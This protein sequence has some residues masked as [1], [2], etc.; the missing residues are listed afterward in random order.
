MSAKAIPSG[1]HTITP[2]FS[3][4]DAAALVAFLKRAF[5]AKEVDVMTS[6]D[7]S[8]MHAQL[9]VGN[10]MV[11]LGQVPPDYPE[12]KLLKAMLYMYIDDVDAAYKKAI[13]AGGKSVMEPTNQFYG[14]RSGAVDDP[15]GNQW[16]IATHIEDMSNEELMRRASQRGK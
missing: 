14:D 13:Q 15:A 9:Q 2:Y 12:D 3:V 6:P 11:M 16:W 8:V 4:R 1:F 10:S 5:D 7:G